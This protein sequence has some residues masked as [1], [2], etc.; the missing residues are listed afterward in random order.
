MLELHKINETKVYCGPGA[1]IAITGKG[2]QE[3]R[4]AINS[5][6]GMRDNQGV[7]RLQLSVL[8][9]SLR[10]LG[11]RY[12]KNSCTERVNLTT[13]AAKHLKKDVRYI[14]YIT[15]HYI[16][17][18]NGLLIDNQYRFGTDISDCRWSKKLVNAYL[19]IKD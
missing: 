2:L 5:V 7:T 4:S 19:E 14:V 16:T 15:G 8:E 11:I 3:V 10:E 18:K 17:V 12:E 6:R 1:L 9:A 13:L